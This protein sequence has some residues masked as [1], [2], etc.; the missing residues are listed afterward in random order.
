MPDD[1][2]PSGPLSDLIQAVAGRLL[3]HPSGKASRLSRDWR[4]AV[5]PL[6][7]AH[8]EP[9]RLQN[10]QL[11]VRVDSSAWLTELTFLTPELL[12]RLQERLP[13]GTLTGLR[14]RQESLRQVPVAAARIPPPPRPHLPE[15]E[16]R[17]LALTAGITDPLLRRA[18]TGFFIA[19]MVFK[20]LGVQ[21]AE[22]GSATG[23]RF[24]SGR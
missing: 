8:T 1:S 16:E 10:G 18:V 11:T 9:V 23:R 13:P 24:P 3:D 17:A 2:A 15:E 19:D 6:L 4:L 5:G 14:F 7:A 12:V 22:P 20:R 21:S